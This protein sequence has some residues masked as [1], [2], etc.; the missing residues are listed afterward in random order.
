M[1]L[2]FLA[3]AFLT[4]AAVRAEDFPRRML[5]VHVGNPLYLNPLT[6]NAPGGPD[7]VR[8]AAER[9]AAALRVPAGKGNNQ[10]FLLSDADAP[11]T[12]RS[13]T[14]AVRSFCETSRAQDRVLLYFAGH[15]FEKGGRA[16]LAP[17]EGDPGDAA[18]LVP[19][20]ELY[21][22]VKA[23]KAAQK[24][25]VWDVCRRNPGRPR[26]RPDAG[27]MTEPLAKALAAA[28]PGVQ[29]VLSCSP[30]ETALEYSEPKGD[31]R[32]FAGSALADAVRQA[33]ED[34]A[35]GQKPDPN[36]PLPVAE[37]FPAIEQYVASAA[38]AY[39]LKQTPKLFGKRPD[40]PAAF[41]PK[42]AP[43]AAAKLSVP[44]DD[45]PT[46]E[47]KSILG[48]LA[49]PPL[50]FGGPADSLPALP[51]LFTRATLKP[52]TPDATVEDI[53]KE[54]EKYKLRVAVLRA[55]QTVRDTSPSADP[56]AAKLPAAI[57][58]PITAQTKK[59]V[60]DAQGPVALALVKLEGELDNL[61][62]CGELRGREP[63][64][65]QAHYDYTLAQVRLRLAVLNESNLALGNVRTETLPDLPAGSR[66]WL[67]AHAEK[68]QSKK[69]VRDLAAAA[70]EGFRTLA[71]NHKGTPWEVLAKR[72][73]LTPPGLR[74][75]VMK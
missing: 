29:V 45:A 37:I 56:R 24:V 33:L 43:P 4:P 58:A 31:A 8:D 41:D 26:V 44:K 63:K 13:V 68:M 10:L 28:P 75:E 46:A 69:P 27:P 67:L 25:V 5:V 42:E 14:A 1:R 3:I 15:A 71:A 36:D 18:T 19:V 40:A 72:A 34:R 48:E 30:G 73:L 62:R 9:L 17:V 52:Y 57:A 32:L 70:E 66:G 11:P 61:T 7:R 35:S 53:L 49:L 21:E 38:K 59:T 22:A 6:S 12:A 23:C 54:A 64:R 74:W 16:Y 55:L 60:L 47:V 39:G 50:D 20:A 51:S 65:W 2:A